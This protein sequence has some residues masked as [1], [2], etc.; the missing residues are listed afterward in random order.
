MVCIF[1]LRCTGQANSI[2]SHALK[3]SLISFVLAR[4][5]GSNYHGLIKFDLIIFVPCANLYSVS[6]NAFP[7]SSTGFNLIVMAFS[8]H[9]V[10]G[11]GGRSRA[12]T[13]VYRNN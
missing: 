4:G 2:F 7:C 5:L 10:L 13:E 8:T 6:G 3:G 11:I 12:T 1:F 9:F